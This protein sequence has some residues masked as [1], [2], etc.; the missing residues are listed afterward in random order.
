MKRIPLPLFLILFLLVATFL[1]A[2]RQLS[3]AGRPALAAVVGGTPTETDIPQPTDTGTPQ[4]T[5]TVPSQPADTET[6]Q[7]TDTDIPTD[8]ATPLPTSTHTPTPEPTDTPLPPTHTPTWT[9]PPVPSDTPTF[10]PSPQPTDTPTSTPEL[11][12]PTPPLP[13]A[14]ATEPGPT[15][16]PSPTPTATATG[17]PPFHFL[18]LPTL[19]FNFSAGEPNN[20]CQEAFT[21]SPNVIYNFYPNDP[22]DWYWFHLT[23]TRN[24]TVRVDN[25]VPLAGQVAV[26][27]GSNCSNAVFLGSNGNFSTTKIVELG[28]QTQ[29]RYFIY[30][31]NDGD[32]NEVV[33]YQLQVQ[34]Q[35][36]G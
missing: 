18:F 3:A 8:T 7:P 30:V 4:P 33:P 28:V 32:L 5:D 31:S 11:P 35:P 19:F 17:G 26:Y 29:G 23:T 15:D 25:F 12:T 13:T 1:S 22:N 36:S 21:I 20:F 14:T 24:L 16:T 6:P 27:K 10:T 34:F 9:P 2:I